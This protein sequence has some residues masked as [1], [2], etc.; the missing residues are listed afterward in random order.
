MTRINFTGRQ[1]IVRE[2]ITLN[3]RGDET[4][5]VFD[6]SANLHGLGLPSNANV[7]AEAYRQ[8]N[9]V[10]LDCG[11][12]GKMEDLVGLALPQFDTPASVR[13]RLKVV[14]A[15]GG[16]E[17]RIL[18]AADQLLPSAVEGQMDRRTLL[19]VRPSPDLGQRLWRLDVAG[20]EPTLW[21]N[22]A[23]GDWRQLVG[24]AS[25]EALVYPEVLRQITLWTLREAEGEEE[26][27]GPLAD[28]H[29]FL[30]RLGFRTQD[31]PGQG[32]DEARDL[33]ID[34]AVEQF[35][36]I[37]KFLDVMATEMSEVG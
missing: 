7:V 36:R 13:F 5:T 15:S 32:D 28:W 29:A 27:T 9:Y 2:R 34:D 4:D 17:G 23:A 31:A 26:L 33:W 8:T 25:F 12:V 21:V 19:P 6:L 35:C 16:E 24:A 11:T 14:G 30:S 37:H 3:R 20:E 1:R 10:R 22:N 18:A